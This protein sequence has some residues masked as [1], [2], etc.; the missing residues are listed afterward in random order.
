MKIKPGKLGKPSRNLRFLL[1]QRDLTKRLGNHVKSINNNHRK[2][3]ENIIGV[4]QVMLGA[5]FTLTNENGYNDPLHLAQGPVK[6]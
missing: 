5:C 6:R 1:G 4:D 3:K 2:A